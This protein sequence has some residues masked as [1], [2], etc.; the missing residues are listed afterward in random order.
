MS[1]LVTVGPKS[2]AVAQGLLAAA[3]VAELP[4]SVVEAVP[5]GFRVPQ[6]VADIFNGKS[7]KKEPAASK[8]KA[9][10]TPAV[11][12]TPKAEEAPP[13]DEPQKEGDE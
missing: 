6:E 3:E 2:K 8:A 1:E 10:E 12:E 4:A 5:G 9:K 11:D 7:A 13:A